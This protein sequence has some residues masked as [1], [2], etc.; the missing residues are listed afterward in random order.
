MLAIWT[1]GSSFI[2]ASFSFL[3]CET[4]DVLTSSQGCVQSWTRFLSPPSHFTCWVAGPA[5]YNLCI[6]LEGNFF[7]PVFE[8]A[9]F[10]SW[11]VT[12]SPMPVLLSITSL[13]DAVRTHPPSLR[14]R[15]H[16]GQPSGLPQD[17]HK[18]RLSGTFFQMLQIP[19]PAALP[20][21]QSLLVLVCHRWIESASSI[22]SEEIWCFLL[23]RPGIW[24]HPW[25]LP[26]QCFTDCSWLLSHSFCAHLGSFFTSTGA[27]RADSSGRPC[28]PMRI[29]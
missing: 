16:W 13:S 18:R 21:L 29:T 27:L 19:K 17:Q 2:Y 12:S 9:T 10:L 5:S 20:P 28:F 26:S 6:P 22:C 24:P 14:S 7:F 23:R 8:A 1:W 25:S 11:V 4:E 15:V 3:F